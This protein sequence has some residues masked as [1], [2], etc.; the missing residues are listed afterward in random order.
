[1]KIINLYY[2]GECPICHQYTLYIKI[3][4]EYEFNIL[5]IREHI[6]KIEF[7][8]S[9]NFEINEGMIIETDSG[10][11]IQG[12][13]AINFL[14]ELSNSNSQIYKFVLTNKFSKFFIKFIYPF[15]KFVRIIL[16]KMI[17]KNHKI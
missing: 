10:L 5:N 3:K 7:F 15:V 13:D 2:D 11:I 17:G 1:M 6:K 12:A 8:R 14:N 4:R 16:L 9:K